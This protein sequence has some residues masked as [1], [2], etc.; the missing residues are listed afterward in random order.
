V[1][2]FVSRALVKERIGFAGDIS[3]KVLVQAGLRTIGTSLEPFI[4]GKITITLIKL[5]GSGLAECLNYNARWVRD[6]SVR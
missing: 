1:Y 5:E 2:S 4:G 6:E 3:T